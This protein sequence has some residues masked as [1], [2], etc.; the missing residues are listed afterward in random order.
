MES[1]ALSRTDAERYQWLRDPE[2]PE[3]AATV[4]R[5]SG[6]ELDAAIDDA[7]AENAHTAVTNLASAAVRNSR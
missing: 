4:A 7:L 1:V 3:A 6:A 2:N 5:F